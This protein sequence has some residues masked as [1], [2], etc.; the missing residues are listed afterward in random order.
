MRN[1]IDST[2]I[3]ILKGRIGQESPHAVVVSEVIKQIDLFQA[4]PP[5]VKER[6]ESLIEGGYVKRQ[7]TNRNNYEYIA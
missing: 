1:I 7:Q 5:S 2:V 3:R 4:Q 6:I